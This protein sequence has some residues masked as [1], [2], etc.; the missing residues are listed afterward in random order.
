MIKIE[1]EIN[2]EKTKEYGKLIIG[3]DVKVS[4]AENEKNASRKEKLVSD[5]IKKCL[6]V[7]KKYQCINKSS[8][9]NKEV[10]DQLIN[11]IFCI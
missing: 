6:Q 10:L 1:I 4:I 9:T 8:L 11:E 7:D 5:H 3:T 2:E